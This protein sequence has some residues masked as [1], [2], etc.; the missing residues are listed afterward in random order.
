MTDKTRLILQNK[1]TGVELS[2]DSYCKLNDYINAKVPNLNT[3]TIYRV[4]P[5]AAEEWKQITHAIKELTQL[6][7]IKH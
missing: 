2:F 5:I 1:K 6:T 4:L 7:S 3:V